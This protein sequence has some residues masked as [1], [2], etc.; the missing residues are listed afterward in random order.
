MVRC[1]VIVAGAGVSAVAG[2]V[3]ARLGHDTLI[4]GEQQEHRPGE[5]LAAGAGADARRLQLNVL[6]DNSFHAPCCTIP[7]DERSHPLPEFIIDREKFNSDL[8][9]AS[10]EAGAK[11]MRGKIKYVF[12]DPKARQLIVRAETTRG[13]LDV[14]AGFAIDATGRKAAVA[15]RCGASRRILTNLVAAWASLPVAAVNHRTGNVQGGNRSRA[16]VVHGG[17]KRSVAAAVL[18][19]HPPRQALPWLEAAQSTVLLHQLSSSTPVTPVP[20]AANVSLLD[21]L[22]GDRWVAAGDAARFR[23]LMRL[24]ALLCDWNR[25]CRCA[26]CRRAA[27][28][29]L[30]GLD[31]LCGARWSPRGA[32]LERSDGSLRGIGRA[33][34]SIHFSISNFCSA[35]TLSSNPVVWITRTSRRREPGN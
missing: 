25:L 16:L 8:I 19:G 22:C 13:P 5:C 14:A 27:R 31:G 11:C 35:I 20:F 9:A 30:D 32:G 23:P 24:R 21:P 28:R 15:R 26:R 2:Y 6:L 33:P 34:D 3:S 17:R 4:I 18:G 7:T 1:D 29:Q 10:V 12:Q